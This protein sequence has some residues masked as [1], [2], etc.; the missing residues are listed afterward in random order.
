M[1]DDGRVHKRRRSNEQAPIPAFP[2]TPFSSSAMT[3]T[4]WAQPPTSHSIRDGS[5]T[6]DFDLAERDPSFESSLQSYTV[7]Y[8]LHLP[9]HLDPSLPVLL[10]CHRELWPAR[11]LWEWEGTDG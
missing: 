2:L 8:S 4:G 10:L 6:L 11:S 3:V 1:D 5:V 7:H 9:E